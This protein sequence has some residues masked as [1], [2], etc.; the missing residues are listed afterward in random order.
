MQ[1]SIELLPAPLGPMMARTLVFTHV[2]RN[3]GQRFHATKTQ[4]DVVDVK[5][6]V[7]YVFCSCWHSPQG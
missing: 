7:A 1:L 3:V 2:E 4:T 5:D 6:D